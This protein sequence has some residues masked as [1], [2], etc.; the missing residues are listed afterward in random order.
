MISFRIAGRHLL[1][2]LPLFVVLAT[3]SAC[4]AE[5]TQATTQARTPAAAA[6]Q[7]P[8]S[9]AAPVAAEA[10]QPRMATYKCGGSGT[11][12]VENRGDSVHVVGTDG[13]EVDLPAAPVTQRSRYGAG[14]DAIVIE[15]REALYMHGRHPPVTC[16]R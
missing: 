16:M 8:A 6:V 5:Q 13:D 14:A 15:G 2:S 9:A 3:A 1:R 7:P 10:A 11:I 4:V 12:T